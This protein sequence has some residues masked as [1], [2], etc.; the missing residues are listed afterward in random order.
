[1]EDCAGE[2]MKENR[3]CHL[4]ILVNFQLEIRP[5]RCCE[6]ELLMYSTYFYSR[7]SAENKPRINQEYTCLGC[8]GYSCLLVHICSAL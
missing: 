3:C 2:N 4:S 5:I 7:R 1:M 8:C 6:F